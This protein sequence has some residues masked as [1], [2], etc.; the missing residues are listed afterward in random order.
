MPVYVDP[1][2]N[3]GIDKPGTPRCFKARS[4][5][6]MFAD[7]PAELH[8]MAELIG[9]RRGWFQASRLLPHYDL[10]EGK[11]WQAVRWGCVELAFLAA[12]PKWK[13]IRH[14]EAWAEVCKPVM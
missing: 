11:R 12:V 8:A 5:C 6:H 13:E 2:K 3:Y 9:L 4:S 14:G 7:T 10:T 1:L